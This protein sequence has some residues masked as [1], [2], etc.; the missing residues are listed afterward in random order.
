LLERYLIN[1]AISVFPT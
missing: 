1:P